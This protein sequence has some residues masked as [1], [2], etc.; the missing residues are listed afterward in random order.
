[1]S[2]EIYH[3]DIAINCKT[4][5]YMHVGVEDKARDTLH[6]I[7]CVT[8]P[9]GDA[10]SE[11]QARRIKAMFEFCAGLDTEFMEACVLAG[12]SPAQAATDYINEGSKK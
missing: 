10:E 12:V 1:M 2:L 11:E 7:L 5:G 6:S 8:G 9:A 4:T 3:G